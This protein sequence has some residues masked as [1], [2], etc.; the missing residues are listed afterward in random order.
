[1]ITS[2][3]TTDLTVPLIQKAAIVEKPGGSVKITERPVVQASDLKVGEVLVKILY[4][5]VCHTDVH[6][7]QGAMGD[8]PM[9]HFIGGHEGSGVIVAI[10]EGT[11]TQLE[12]G[13]AVGI[14]WISKSCLACEA[15][16]REGTFQ[17]YVVSSHAT[18]VI[19]IPESLPLY[20]AAPILC[21]GLSVYG[22][23]KQSNTA[24]GD[25]VV[26]T[27]AGGGLGHLAIQ[28]A[29]NAFNLRVIA[30]DTG[31]NKKELCLKLGAEVFIDFKATTEVK[32]VA[33]GVGAHAVLVTSSAPDSYEGVVEYLRPLGTLLALGVDIGCVLN[34]DMLTV[35]S[36]CITVKGIVNGNREVLRQALDIA[37]RGRVHTICRIEPLAKL[38]EVFEELRAGKLAGRVVLNL[39]SS[40]RTITFQRLICIFKWE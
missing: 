27:G 20:S 40:G 30:I 17:Q 33:D 8:P 19:P 37:A 2:H 4:S 22:A 24:P 21:A 18:H 28:Y 15:C 11:H 1:M 23:L 34:L 14:N 36:R 39:V 7:A 29:I 31:D 32:Q 12:V 9:K 38:P 35:V 10:G 25:I 26:I 5:G 6:I 13:Q 3:P 16:L